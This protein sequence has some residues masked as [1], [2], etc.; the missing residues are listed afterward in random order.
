MSAKELEFNFKSA[1]MNTSLVQPVESK[2][3]GKH[4]E[5]LCR[6]VPGQEASWLQLLPKIL[7]LAEEHPVELHLCR[8]Y[9]LRNGKLVF[10]W[11]LSIE[12]R[13]NATLKTAV[14][15]VIDVLS[16]AKPVLNHMLPP[17]K[18]PAQKSKDSM[19][20][21]Y[22]PGPDFKPAKKKAAPPGRPQYQTDNYNQNVVYEAMGT[23]ST[24]QNPRLV[25]AS[26]KVVTGERGKQQIEE[27]VLMP[28]AHVYTNDMNKPNERGRGA[29]SVGESPSI[30]RSN[31][32][33]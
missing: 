23:E 11:H 20:S 26:R 18:H 3:S 32:N 17:G 16:K 14:E 22:Q 25:L 9:V 8:K 5:V 7:K 28:L 24:A 31:R 30:L 10:G 29:Q 12:A 27:T 21:G 6:Q 2:G 33:S 4:I 15:A 19:S 1:L 13:A